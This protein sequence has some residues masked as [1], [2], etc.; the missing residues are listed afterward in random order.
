MSKGRGLYPVLHSVILYC[1]IYSIEIRR[2]NTLRYKYVI[3]ICKGRVLVVVQ[4]EFFQPTLLAPIDFTGIITSMQL[5][6]Y[7]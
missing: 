5:E 4:T 3:A 6:F 1:S 7:A 2:E